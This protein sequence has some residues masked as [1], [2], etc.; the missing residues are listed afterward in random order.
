MN[1][2][3]K[4]PPSFH[5]LDKEV[6]TPVGDLNLLQMNMMPITIRVIIARI[7]I[8]ANQ[9][10]ASPKSFTVNRFKDKNNRIHTNAGTQGAIIF[11][12]RYST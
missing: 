11:G 4:N 10:S 8:M 1:P 3:G 6:V 5:I 7:L 12:K 9:N 2:V